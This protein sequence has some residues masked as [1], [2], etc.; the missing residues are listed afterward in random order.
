MNKE[1]ERLVYAEWKKT[2]DAALGSGDVQQE[3]QKA[4]TEGA[5]YREAVERT[6]RGLDGDDLSFEDEALL[7]DRV[8]RRMMT[9]SP[10]LIEYKL[11]NEGGTIV[12][13]HDAYDRERKKKEFMEF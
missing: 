6:E 9:E 5:D 10:I 12:P 1:M 13:D 2:L 4:V 3:I 8:N 11:R 7:Q